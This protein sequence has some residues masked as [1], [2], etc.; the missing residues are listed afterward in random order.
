VI[1]REPF[2]EKYIDTVVASNDSTVVTFKHEFNDLL[3]ALKEL[4]LEVDIDVFG[5]GITPPCITDNEPAA[6]LA[7][8]YPFDMRD[9]SLWAEWNVRIQKENPIGLV[10]C[11]Q[12]PY[13]ALDPIFNLGD[14]QPVSQCTNPKK[15]QVCGDQCCNK[16]DKC[17]KRASGWRCDRPPGSQSGSGC[18]SGL[19]SLECDAAGG[20]W[21]P[22]SGC[23]CP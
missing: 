10:V 5:D 21:D 18:S 19:G 1:Q 17:V 2:R 22:M 23:S 14:T 9:D 7:C 16:D 13:G 8:E 4:G 6:P 3:K 11:A 15:P 12:V 20:S